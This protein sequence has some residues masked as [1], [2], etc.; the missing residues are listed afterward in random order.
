MVSKLGPLTF[1]CL[2]WLSGACRLSA[3]TTPATPLKVS[4]ATLTFTYQEGDVKLPVAQALAVTGAAGGA[5]TITLAGGP[6]LATSLAG[7]NLPVSC[8]VLA[9]PTSLA[10]GTYTGTV[11]VATTGATSQSAAVPVTLTVKAAPSSLTASFSSVV[12]SFVRGGTL[13]SPVPISL[14]SSGAVLSYSVS[15]AG[16]SW[17]TVTP[18]SGIAFPAFP[19]TITLNVDPT[20]LAP[21]PYKGTVT[22]AAPQASNKSQTIT[23]NLTVGPGLPFINSVWPLSVT[24][25]AAAMTVTITGTN[26]FSGSTIKVGSATLT[27]TIFGDGAAT[28]VIP[29]EL[30]VNPGVVGVTV[31]NPGTGGGDSAAVNLL[32]NAATPSITAVVN[33]A[34]FLDGPVA[35][36]EMVTLFGIRLGP[37]A[38]TSFTP[39]APG[40]PIASTLNLTTVFFDN[41]PAPILFT[42][43]RQVAVMVPY[44]VATKAAVGIHVTYNGV[45]STVLTKLVAPS[46]PGLF[47]AAGT[48]TGQLAAFNVDETN[49]TVTLNT[50]TA[51]VSKGGMIV[52][53]ATG[54]GATF[55]ASSDGSIVGAPSAAPNPGLSLQIGGSNAT[56]L[57]AGG[58]VGLVSGIIQINARIPTTITATKATPVILTVNGVPS[59]PGTTI[60]IK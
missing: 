60:G 8:K 33:G 32:V 24:E 5:V 50:E 39:P 54:E 45:S 48:G 28:A 42:S 36:G 16:A 57:Y 37:D 55:P 31:S 23:V 2:A 41:T 18:K 10:V 44:D 53:Y 9:N 12:V 56:I 40:Q 25:G 59:P 1:V 29:A 49:G 27:S 19:G 3:Q 46:V 4:P 30:L 26:F 21:G 47:S 15:T 7:G 34:T 13:P 52:L 6:W 17:L 38:L 43:A 14:T 20:G 35:P 22:V 51:T 11:T 58:V